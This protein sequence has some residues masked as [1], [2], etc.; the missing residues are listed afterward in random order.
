MSTKTTTTL[1]QTA[2]TTTLHG[3]RTAPAE[4][5]TKTVNKAA[6]NLRSHSKPEC[7]VPG[8]NKRKEPR[9]RAWEKFAKIVGDAAGGYDQKQFLTCE[10]DMTEAHLGETP[11]VMC[12]KHADQ[13]HTY[14][15][16]ITAGHQENKDGGQED[17]PPKPMSGYTQDEL[18]GKFRDLIPWPNDELSD[19][20]YASTWRT[21]PFSA[22]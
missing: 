19:G 22:E 11:T 16:T 8:M 5:T 17:S 10:G 6:T 20:G 12:R 13:A 15:L 18:E 21:A 14:G 2:T 1:S 3:G 4:A 7:A 9:M